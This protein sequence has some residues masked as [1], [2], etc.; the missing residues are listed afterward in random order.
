M[1]KVACGVVSVI[2][3][4][5]RGAFRR[6]TAARLRGGAPCPAVEEAWRRAHVLVMRE[7]KCFELWRRELAPTG[8]QAA[9]H[10]LGREPGEYSRSTASEAP[11]ESLRPFAVDEPN[12]GRKVV[13]LL[14]L[15][16]EESAYYADENEV[17][18]PA[19][20]SYQLGRE[21]EERYGFV[22]GTED[23]YIRYLERPDVQQLWSWD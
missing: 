17:V 1:W 16:A 23:D 9:A 5:S 10:P 22:A 3:G 7:A 19:G 18:D 14:V 11:R 4:L 21:I 12:D 20:K 8:V 6:Q 13:M 2:N 15:S